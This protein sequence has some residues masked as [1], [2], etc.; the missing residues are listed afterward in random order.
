M[1]GIKARTL[2]D[3]DGVLIEVVEENGVENVLG[4]ELWFHGASIVA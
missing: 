4:E 2:T 1:K 3:S